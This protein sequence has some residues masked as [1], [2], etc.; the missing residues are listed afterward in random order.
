M[1]YCVLLTDYTKFTDGIL[2]TTNYLLLFLKITI[3]ESN[4]VGLW[5]HGYRTR[6]VAGRYQIHI[7]S[8]GGGGCGGG[9]KPI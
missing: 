4:T 1:S 5:S 2:I 9:S 3:F 8:G 6:N 7:E